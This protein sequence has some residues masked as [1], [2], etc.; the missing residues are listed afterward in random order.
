MLKNVPLLITVIINASFV[1]S[2][3]HTVLERPP[4]IEGCCETGDQ[5]LAGS[6]ECYVNIYMTTTSRPPTAQVRMTAL[7]PIDLSA[8]FD[9]I[10][11][12]G[13]LQKRIEYSTGMSGSAD[14]LW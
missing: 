6:V 2:T 3:V 14:V 12:N 10:D 11:H 13:I 8:A 5:W 9:I 7:V 1:K 4:L